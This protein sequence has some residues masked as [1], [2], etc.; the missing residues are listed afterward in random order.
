MLGGIERLL[1]VTGLKE[2]HRDKLRGSQV[3]SIINLTPV[4]SFSNLFLAGLLVWLVRKS[5]DF[6]IV[7][8]W[9]SILVFLITFAMMSWKRSRTRRSHGKASLSTIR[10]LCLNAALLGS[11]WGVAA[12]LFATTGDASAKIV[13]SVGLVAVLAAGGVALAAIPAAVISFSLPVAIGAAY[14]LSLESNTS[15]IIPLLVLLAWLS[16]TTPIVAFFYARLF[17]YFMGSSI[18]AKEQGALLGMFLDEYRENSNDWLWET[19]SQGV[20][21]ELPDGWLS[22]DEADNE[23]RLIDYLERTITIKGTQF[24]DLCNAL[25]KCEAFKDIL[26]CLD[27]GRG[28]LWVRLNGHPSFDSDGVFT[29]YVGIGSD[30]T[31][32]KLAEERIATLSKSDSLTGLMN[33]NAYSE[34]LSI[35]VANLERY[36][37]PFTILYLDLDGFKLVNDTRGHVLGDRI[38]A[39]VS[40]RIADEVREGD[41]IARLG[42]DEFAILMEGQG[43]AGSAARLAARL[44]SEI[45]EPYQFEDEEYRVGLSIGIA[46]APVNGT[47]PD[48]LLR[49]ADLALYRA[50]AD[51]RGV[52]RFFEN[53]MDSEL[54]ERRMLEA[55]LKDAVEKNELV[56]HFQPLVDA[57]TRKTVGME[58]LIRW[59]HPIRGLLSPAEFVELAEMSPLI[60]DIGRWTIQKACETAREWPDG[61]FVA[62]NL[63]AHHFMRSDIVAEAAE[64]LEKTGLEPSRL[65]LEIT[66]SLLMNKADEVTHKLNQLKE[67]GISVAMDDFGTGYS[68]LSYLMSVPFDKL[69]IDKSFVDQV[70]GNS[71]GKTIVRMITAL[72]R[73]L[74]LK[75]TAEGVEQK[76]Q[77]DFLESV[78]CDQLQG[79]MFSK[80]MKEEDLPAYFLKEA[81]SGTKS[82]G[83]KLVKKTRKNKK[84]A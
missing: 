70:T 34:R 83:K 45:G 6:P 52:F 18:K 68:S 41:S 31:S 82:A 78:N 66:E 11:L 1:G 26:L 51:G 29:G 16:I 76:S 46:M 81:V 40:E 65:E 12:V 62:V 50:K 2:S 5:D 7:L 19:D 44:I 75:V 49:N 67:V 39:E 77:A 48:Q 35:A 64:A 72:A 24:D 14:S 80:P 58:S 32:E 17:V 8:A 15:L 20:I 56:L 60:C 21:D 55:E 71:S 37:K 57:K 63:S 27:A 73:E 22:G 38:L 84:S 30:V 36:G 69:K 10:R 43:D 74:N 13:L 33:R 9:A 79:Y 25:E 4:M 3:R 47:R 28:E 42:G 59:E 61:T 53:D 23:I 54:R